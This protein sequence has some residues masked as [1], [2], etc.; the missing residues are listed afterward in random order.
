[1]QMYFEIS[2]MIYIY[3]YGTICTFLLTLNIFVILGLKR[4][5]WTYSHGYIMDYVLKISITL[6]VQSRLIFIIK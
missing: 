3:I 5:K 6:L 2:V 1:M 4:D